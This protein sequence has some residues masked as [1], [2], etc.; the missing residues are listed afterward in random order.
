[1]FAKIT[2]NT[3]AGFHGKTTLHEEN[4]FAENRFNNL[5]LESAFYA[6]LLIKVPRLNNASRRHA[7]K[8]DKE[9][10]LE[11]TF[12]EIFGQFI[13]SRA[14]ISNMRLKE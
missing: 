9:S 10:F 3:V 5:E 2:A 1:M 4:R 7:Y 6:A 14:N 12:Q 11:L 13:R 8:R